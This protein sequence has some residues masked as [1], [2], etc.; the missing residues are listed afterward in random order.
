MPPDRARRTG[1]QTRVTHRFDLSPLNFS[2]IY[3]LV[4]DRGDHPMT[5]LDQLLQG[6]SDFGDSSGALVSVYSKAA[7]NKTV[8]RWQRDADG[9]LFFVSPCVGIRLFLLEYYRPVYS[10]PPRT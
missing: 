4:D 7:E 5:T 9:I 1:R 8:G 10:L 6:E 3:K 2:T